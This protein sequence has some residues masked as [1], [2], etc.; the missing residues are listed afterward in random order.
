MTSAVPGVDPRPARRQA[1]F[2]TILAAAWDVANEQGLA[3]VSL[4]EVARRVGLRQ[5]SLYAYVDSKNG[6]Y[7][8]MFAQAAQALLEHMTTADYPQEP[9]PAVV[10]MARAMWGFVRENPAEGQLLFER[11]IPGFEPSSASYSVAQNFQS[12]VVD[13]LLAAGVADPGDVDICTALVAGL[14]SAQETN[15]PGGDR[16]FRHLETVFGMFF[17]YLDNKSVTPTVGASTARHATHRAEP[18][19]APRPRSA[20]PIRKEGHHDRRDRPTGRG[21]TADRP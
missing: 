9:R 12:W 7:D 2:Q 10:I 13:K 16:W 11:T 17:A 15:E 8:A 3:G 14:I 6:L 5:P 21:N 19:V 1:R 4:H 20:P 18:K